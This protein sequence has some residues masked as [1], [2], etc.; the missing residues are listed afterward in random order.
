MQE[1]F[2]GIPGEDQAVDE[3]EG[4]ITT[5]SDSPDEN[6]TWA[7]ETGRPAAIVLA[8][9][10]AE[11]DRHFLLFC[12]VNPARD[13]ATLDQIE[14]LA[15]EEKRLTERIDLN[16]HPNDVHNQILKASSN[17]TATQ[18]KDSKNFINKCRQTINQQETLSTL[19]EALS[20]GETEVVEDL[21]TDLFR[22]EIFPGSDLDLNTKIGSNMDGDTIEE[23]PEQTAETDE[24]PEEE[25]QDDNEPLILDI[26]PEVNPSTGVPLKELKPGTEIEIRVVGDSVDELRDQFQVNDESEEGRRKS[27]PLYTKLLQV[28]SSEGEDQ[29]EF[30]TKITHEVYG[31]GEVDENTL[32]QLRREEDMPTHILLRRKILNILLILVA[33]LFS[34]SVLI[35]LFPDAFLNVVAL[36]R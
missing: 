29:A 22:N 12:I 5:D 28:D 16:Q 26:I 30:L 3:T 35:L 32:V 19:G 13:T 9:E 34:T 10:A 25:T 24:E 20:K 31:K 1:T 27:K 36:L 17:A 21:F 8:G 6:L 2:E 18:Q 4:E 15:E 14:G 33:F 23:D 11:Y 7:Y